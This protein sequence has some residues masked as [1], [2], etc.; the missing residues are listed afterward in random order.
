[1]TPARFAAASG[2]PAHAPLR[3]AIVG[4]GLMGR[5]HA[6]AV[7]RAG[8][9]VVAVLDADAARASALTARHAG[10]RVVADLAQLA[11]DGPVD[12]VHICTPL[13]TH[14]SLVRDALMRGYHV[15]AEK[16]L[17][18]SAAETASLLTLAD[19]HGR[20]LA[21]VHQMLFQRGVQAVPAYLARIGPLLHVDFTAC[22]AG[23]AHRPVYERD[24][25][26]REVLPHPLS[27][28]ARLAGVDVSTVAWRTCV[29][30]PGEL[31]VD[32]MVQETTVSMLI[33]TGGRPTTNT[34][35][36]IGARGTVSIDLF[37]GFATCVMARDTR[38]GKLMLPFVSSGAVLTAATTN[39]VRRA[40]DREPAYPGLAA[41]VR[42]FY[43]AVR[44]GTEAPVSA[45]E[46]LEVARAMDVIV[47]HAYGTVAGATGGDVGA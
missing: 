14:A 31:R 23:A 46:T 11:D 7:A 36:L 33:S 21:P 37:H 25:V 27:L 42:R 40:I 47:R 1:M 12:V 24:Q 3:A 45:R 20:L 29:S 19:V 44:T 32:G 9:A 6:H 28:A 13:P 26:V 4:A 15:L 5:W 38:A 2:T 41:L 35:R 34:V 8:H 10:A 22:T 16:P 17:A 39:L 18:D 30:Q 43:G